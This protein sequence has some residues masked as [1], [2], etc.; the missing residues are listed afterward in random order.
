MVVVVVD[1]P[2]VPHEVEEVDSA[3]VDV[4]A[5]DSLPV[6]QA[7]VVSRE[8]PQ[9]DVVLVVAEGVRRVVILRVKGKMG[10]LG[11]CL[12]QGTVYNTRSCHRGLASVMSNH[13]VERRNEIGYY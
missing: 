9:E 7:A 5:V 8:E 10:V 2:V 1:S 13:I 12:F 11:T 4:E 6:V 3:L